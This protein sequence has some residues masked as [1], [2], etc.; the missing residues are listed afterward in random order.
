MASMQVILNSLASN[1][2]SGSLAN[3]VQPSIPVRSEVTVV[4]SEYDWV[5]LHAWSKVDC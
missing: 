5:D 2:T 1:T 4:Q 3:V